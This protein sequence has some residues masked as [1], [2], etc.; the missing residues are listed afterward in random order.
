MCVIGIWDHVK[1]SLLLF[2][3]H[4][5]THLW[6]FH[7][8]VNW[9][10][11]IGVC[12]SASLFK[13]PGFFLVFCRSQQCCSLNGPYSSS[14][15]QVLQSLYQ[16]LVTVPSTQITIGI[17]MIVFFQIT[18]KVYVHITFFHFPSVL[19]CDQLERQSLLFGRFSFFFFFFFFV[20]LFKFKLL[21]QF[22]VDKRSPPSCVKS[23]T[24]FARIYRIRLLCDWSFHLYQYII[25]IC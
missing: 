12:V 14:Y 13:S 17:T 2:Y 3:Y 24:L 6:V 8:S 22:P 20:R 18:S 1:K 25:L 16:P 9:W 21:S 7:T 15:F 5:L 19:P 23:Y 4:Y 10:F 11:S